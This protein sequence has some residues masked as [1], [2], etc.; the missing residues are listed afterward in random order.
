MLT[1]EFDM[2]E[3]FPDQLEELK[4]VFTESAGSPRDSLVV[5]QELT[6]SKDRHETQNA[7]KGML[8]LQLPFIGA[9]I[10]GGKIVKDSVCRPILTVAMMD[11]QSTPPS[12]RKEQLSDILKCFV[13]E[14]A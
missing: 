5:H 14:A 11:L 3:C 2:L 1:A 8:K 13:A 6:T 7:A 4:A 9:D 12:G 10:D